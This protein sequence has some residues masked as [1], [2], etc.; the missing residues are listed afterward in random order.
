MI[1]RSNAFQRNQLLFRAAYRLCVDTIPTIIHLFGTLYKSRFDRNRC[2][3]SPSS[4][5]SSRVAPIA[6]SFGWSRGQGTPLQR[7]FQPARR[8]LIPALRP[9]QSLPDRAPWHASPPP[10][11]HAPPRHVH[12]AMDDSP[13]RFRDWITPRSRWNVNE[14]TW[15]SLSALK[16]L[17]LPCDYLPFLDEPSFLPPVPSG[18]SQLIASMVLVRVRARLG[19]ELGCHGERPS[20]HPTSV[21]ITRM[22][23]TPELLK[24]LTRKTS[25]ANLKARLVVQTLKPYPPVKSYVSPGP[26]SALLRPTSDC[27]PRGAPNY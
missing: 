21:S 5:D 24:I 18:D 19:R 6:R 20:S 17:S 15:A 16:H 3:V 1:Q 10:R 8:R 4:T 9:R 23:I 2:A 12:L 13:T 25:S 14:P 22:C 11:P 26:A 7:A 27:L